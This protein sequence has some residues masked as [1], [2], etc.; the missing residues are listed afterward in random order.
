MDG[1]L[2][3]AILIQ[4]DLISC[5]QNQKGKT[6]YIN[7]QQLMKETHGTGKPNEHLFPFKHYLQIKIQ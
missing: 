1:R 7:W 2:T 6:K 3:I 4:S 5:P